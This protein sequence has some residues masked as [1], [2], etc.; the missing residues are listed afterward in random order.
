MTATDFV[1]QFCAATTAA[2]FDAM[3]D[4]LAP[5]AELISP[6]SG[7]LVFRGKDDLRVLL[8]AAYGSLTGLRWTDRIGDGARRVLLAEATAGPFKLTEALVIDL[9]ADGRIRS[10]RPHL[11]PWLT[12]T[13]LAVLLSPRLLRHPGV[14]RRA[15]R[16]ATA[17]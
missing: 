3:V 5:D 12:L 13:A 9:A 1:A 6:L 7:R 4:T 8:T 17:P 11:R 16:G 10:L 14:M 15:M 2:D